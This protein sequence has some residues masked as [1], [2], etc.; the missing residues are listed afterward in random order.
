MRG[1]LEQLARCHDRLRDGLADLVDAVMHLER[2]GVSE[3]AWGALR[4]AA[5][6]LERRSRKHEEDEELSLFPRLGSAPEPVG[7]ALETLAEEHRAHDVLAAELRALL[8]REASPKEL[9]ELCDA[10]TE[11]Y[12]RHMDL[13]ERVVFPYAEATMDRETRDAMRAEMDDRRGR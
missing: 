2:N 9:R 10:M 12:A 1:A 6:D 5:A 11:S 8:A 7:G 4:D 13:E 3:E